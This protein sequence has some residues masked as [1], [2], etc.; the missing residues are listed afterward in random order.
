MYYVTVDDAKCTD[1][2][3]CAAIWSA[4]YHQGRCWP[5]D[6]SDPDDEPYR[7]LG[8]KIYR[9]CPNDA[10]FFKDRKHTAKL[11]GPSIGARTNVRP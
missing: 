9:A 2:G 8:Q 5:L 7:E 6:H 10:I 4:W 3:R 1:C 11:Y